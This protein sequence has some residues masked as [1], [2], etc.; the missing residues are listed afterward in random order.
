MLISEKTRKIKPSFE[1]VPLNGSQSFQVR[2]FVLEA[3][4]AQY[5]FHPEY[6]LTLIEKGEGKRFVGNHLDLFFEG[7]LVLLGPNLPHCWRNDPVIKGSVNAI[8]V[9]VQFM[10]DFLGDQFF[11]KP[12]LGRIRQLL[13]NSHTGLIFPAEGNASARQKMIVLNE[14]E[15]YFERLVLLLALLQELSFREDSMPLD[16]SSRNSRRP[17]AEQARVTP[18]LSYIIDHFRE[19]CT[20]QQAAKVAN[21]T[22]NAFCKYFKKTTRKTFM[23]MVIDY[24]LNYAMAQLVHTDKPVS[25]ICF[26]SGFNDI[27]HF[28]RMFKT[29]LKSTPLQYRQQF[30]KEMQLL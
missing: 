27:T 15:D 25:H 9:V 3:F 19:E 11:S 1:A 7:E 5:H 13:E 24:R 18:V 28:S 21:M 26:E 2:G 17:N 30:R 4:D 20:L 12:E 23:E 6:E 10:P 8:S 29:K 22:T 14:T 16:T